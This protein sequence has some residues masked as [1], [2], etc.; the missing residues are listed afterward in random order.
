MRRYTD[1]ATFQ[2]AAE[3]CLETIDLFRDWRSL[4]LDQHLLALKL[5]SGIEP[6]HRSRRG[7]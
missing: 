1:L 3:P 5:Q 6:D 4:S 7:L 2:Q